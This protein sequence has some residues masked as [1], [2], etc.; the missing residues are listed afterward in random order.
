MRPDLLSAVDPPAAVHET[1][2][3]ADSFTL[4]VFTC[5]DVNHSSSFTGIR[6]VGPVMNCVLM[7][8]R[9]RVDHE[10]RALR[11]AEYVPRTR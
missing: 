5:V 11:R 7:I 6:D 3:L 9:R 8:A 10:S 2:L 1:V 4:I